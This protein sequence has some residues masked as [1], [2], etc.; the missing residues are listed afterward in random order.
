[1]QYWEL[2]S[3]CYFSLIQSRAVHGHFFGLDKKNWDHH[4]HIDLYRNNLSGELEPI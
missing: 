1:M 4:L 3:F 2:K